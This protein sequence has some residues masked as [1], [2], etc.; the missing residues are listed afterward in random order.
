MPYA[1][2]NKKKKQ[3][4]EEFVLCCCL[5]QVK[6]TLALTRPCTELL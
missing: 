4:E 3:N 5:N 2:N 6:L 1:F